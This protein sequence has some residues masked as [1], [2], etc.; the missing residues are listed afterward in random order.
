MGTVVTR[1]YGPLVIAGIIALIMILEYYL[2]PSIVGPIKSAATEIRGMATIINVTAVFLAIFILVKRNIETGNRATG[3]LDKFMSYMLV[4]FVA[5][6]LV[7]AFGYGKASDEYANFLE[8]FYT[9]AGLGIMGTGVYWTW[10]GG[11]RALRM[12]TLDGAALFL[13][14]MVTMIGTAGWGR[15][16]I[17]GSEQVAGFFMKTVNA[18]V[19]RGIIIGGGIGAA[20]AAFRTVIGKERAFVVGE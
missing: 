17:P 19:S 3:I 4:G 12:R 14:A 20:T 9:A 6:T 15:L 1:R 18:S 8:H 11:Y 7:I 16:Y 5:V 10:Y 2:A 13:A